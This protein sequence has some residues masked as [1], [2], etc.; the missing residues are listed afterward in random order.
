MPVQHRFNARCACVA[1]GGSSESSS[2][3]RFEDSEGRPFAFAT[4]PRQYE[5]DRPFLVDHLALDLALDVAKKSV[6][7]SATLTVRRVDP[8]AESIQLDAIGFDISAV[9]VDGADV[10]HTYDGRIIGVPVGKAKE[11]AKITVK[12]SATP[13]RGLYFLEPDEFVSDRPRQVWSQCQEE[14]ARHW[15]P[16]HDKPHV[17]MTTEIVVKVPNGWHA[18]SNGDLLNKETPAAPAPWSFHYKMSDPHPSYL[19]TLVA[20]EF[21]E[22]TAMA[23]KTPLAY[24]V[25]RGR[26]ADGRRTFERTPDMI[27]HFGELL[28]VA[29]PWS[30]YTQVVVSDFIFGGMENT[31]ATTMYEYIL[32]DPR[33]AVDV[34]SDD[35]IAHEL[36]HQWF[37]DFITCRDW[38]EAWLNEGFAT[39]MEHVWREKNLGKD[40]YDYAIKGDLEVYLAEAHGRY[41][42]PVVCQDYDAPLDLFDRH[43]YEKGGLVLHGLRAELG[44]KLFWRGIQDY[45]TRNARGV[46]ETRDLQR[47]LEA[48]SG[49]SLGKYFE[50]CVYKPGHPELEVTVAW[51]KEVLTVAIKQEQSATDGVPHAFDVLL[52]LDVADTHGSRRERVRITERNEQFA[53]PCATRPSYVVVDPGMRVL[54]DVRLKLPSDML[55][56]QLQKAP[57]ARGRW[58]AARGLKSFDDPS[59]VQALSERLFDDAEFWGVR[60]EAAGALGD[61]RAK[62]CFDALARA[63]SVKH[64]KVRRGVMNALGKFRTQAAADALRPHALKDESYVVEAE[65]ARALGNT[66]QPFAFETLLDVID[67]RSWADIISVGAI[68]GLAALRDDRAVPHVLTRLRYGHP[69]RTRRAAVIALPKLSTDRKGREALEDLL[70]DSDPM[71]RLDVAR[72]LG[73][74]G[75]AKSRPALRARLDVDLDPRVRRRLRETL[76]DL[77]QHGAR[78][79]EQVKE[80]LD[81]LR[82]EHAELKARMGNLEARVGGGSKTNGASKLVVSDKPDKADRPDRAHKPGKVDRRKPAGRGKGMALMPRKENKGG[83]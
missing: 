74:L 75:D 42:R 57:T 50:Q 54:G 59:T 25:P 72:A 80:D 16:C 67:R 77:G 39:Y 38:S 46:V 81:K 65:A 24:L 78:G 35:L 20:G 41:R 11:H 69:A 71:L 12:Y 63:A 82:I 37:G 68:D 8:D 13:R 1:R 5:R 76:R 3:G 23:G 48:V 26:E 60:V 43:L 64:P 10:V 19:L 51:D 9:K 55:R 28:G 21:A 31:T 14:D 18:L 58:L 17:K 32:L 62:E 83:A 27:N 6:K 4:S 40:E 61:I 70:D 2:V 47:A 7:G 30:R 56:H 45:L 36:A 66:K 52:E 44:P 33:A 15:V 73:E 29:Y 79:V 34:S 22:L 53:I 49:K